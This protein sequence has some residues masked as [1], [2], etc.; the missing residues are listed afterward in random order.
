MNP[1]RYEG[2]Y[3]GVVLALVAFGSLCVMLLEL[4]RKGDARD[5]EIV[6]MSGGF[7]LFCGIF[8]LVLITGWVDLLP[9]SK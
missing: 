5:G 9:L 6:S 3:Y 4:R 7:A 8:A 2:L 1:A